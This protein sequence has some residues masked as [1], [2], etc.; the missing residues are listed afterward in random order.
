M[1]KVSAVL[2]GAGSR[3]RDFL[4]SYAI[5]NPH[6]IEFVAV[7]EPNDE[8]REIFARIH[9]IKDEM[10]F[11]SY[12]DLLNQPKLADAVIISTQDRMHYE[13]TM[14]SISKGYHILLEKPMATTPKE[15]IIMSNEARKENRVFFICYVLRYTQFFSRIKELLAKDTIGK[16]ISIQHNEN[17]G[18]YHYAHSYVR[19]NWRNSIDSSPMILAKSCHD[20]DI[21][22]WLVDSDCKNVS[23]FGDLMYFKKENAPE[24]SPKRCLDGCSHRD[25]CPFNAQK[26]Y[27]TSNIDWPTCTISED[28]SIEGRIKALENGLYGRC[29][30]HCDNNVVD[31][32][33]VNMEFENGVTA[34]FTMCA[35][36]NEISRTLKLMGTKGEIRG[37]FEKN[38]IE[39]IYF[40]NNVRDIIK[41]PPSIFGHGGGDDALMREFVKNVM[42]PSKEIETSASMSLQSHLIA[43]AAE[44][45]RLQ[46]KVINIKK[47]S[48]EVAKK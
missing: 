20:M 40:N 27:L 10:C 29:V 33:V 47:Y 21:L 15:C 24:N 41:I 23:S 12:E 14:K 38:E 22:L 9:N 11:K 43:F 36:T 7:A 1:K 6:E 19:G 13:P 35:F 42:E 18:Y 30:F 2:I 32:Q 44:E 25:E 45:S 17:V 48:S 3:G 46:N 31:H 16:L 39:V 26:L 28:L 4:A 34:A 5:R 37:H 8:R